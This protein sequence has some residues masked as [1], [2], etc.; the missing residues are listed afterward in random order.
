V[1]VAPFVVNQIKTL[2]L[3]VLFL[4]VMFMMHIFYNCNQ[5]G[6]LERDCPNTCTICMYYRAL[7]HVRKDCPQLLEK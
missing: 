6:H 7:D 1:D 3:D 5:P 4:C 2:C